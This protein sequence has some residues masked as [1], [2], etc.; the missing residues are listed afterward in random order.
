MNEKA[1]IT[2]IFDLYAHNCSIPVNRE[3]GVSCF[4]M[5]RL[6]PHVHILIGVPI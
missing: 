2:V 6:S 5:Y 1:T 4:R 3:Q